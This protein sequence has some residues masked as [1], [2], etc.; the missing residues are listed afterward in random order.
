[1]KLSYV[2]PLAIASL[3]ALIQPGLAASRNEEAREKS[4]ALSTV[5]K[6]AIDAAKKAL[7]GDPTEAKTIA[8]TKPQQYELSVKNGSKET[9]VHVKGDGTIVKRESESDEDADHDND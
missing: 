9:S 8:G 3:F 5:P 2:A 6:P 7:G 1:M 4:I